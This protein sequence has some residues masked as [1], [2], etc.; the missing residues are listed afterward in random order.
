MGGWWA[1][2]IS[3]TCCA[4][5]WCKAQRGS[6]LRRTPADTAAIRLLVL[7]VDGV[8]TD[9]RLWLGAAGEILKSFHVRD[10]HGI[11]AVLAAGVQVAVLSGRRS[12]AVRA[13]C[14]ELGIRHVIQ[15]S[16]D[17]LADF[18]RLA[19]RL[20][21]EASQCACIGDDVPDVPLMRALGLAFAVAD[22]HEEARAAADRTTRLAGGCGAV[23]EV[24]DLLLSTRKPPRRARP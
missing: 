22:A 12:A 17:K 3:T 8:L 11:R 13:R 1:P 5:A 16:A 7:D 15:G 18:R 24:C 10:G 23:R 4:P 2:S 14:R 20:T 21:L 19:R 6:I 9:G